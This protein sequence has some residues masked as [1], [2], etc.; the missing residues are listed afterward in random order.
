MNV[1]SID[2]ATNGKIINQIKEELIA[3]SKEDLVSLI[4]NERYNQFISSYADYNEND[5]PQDSTIS[6]GKSNGK[7]VPYIGW[8][9]RDT[10]FANKLISIGDCGEYIG[11][12][13]NNKWD[14]SE[15]LLTSEECD[16]V[17]EI[18]EKAMYEN[19]KG[20]DLVRIERN[21]LS[22]LEKLWPYLQTLSI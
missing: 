2:R 5:K 19:S 6:N 1:T 15:R 4:I 8:F 20:G 7:R 10:N 21:I 16:K 18:I 12:M 22:E 3:E 14:Y 11:I 9:W 17:I 13:E